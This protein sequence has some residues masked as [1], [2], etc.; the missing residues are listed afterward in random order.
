M[1]EPPLET[2][3]NTLMVKNGHRNWVKYSKEQVREMD[4]AQ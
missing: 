3:N 1:Y 4:L 2:Q